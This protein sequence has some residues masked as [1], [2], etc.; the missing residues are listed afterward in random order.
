MELPPMTKKKPEPAVERRLGIT[1]MNANTRRATDPGHEERPA[2]EVVEL[3]P[4]GPAR[5]T[6][7]LRAL[8]GMPKPDATAEPDPEVGDVWTFGQ[9]CM[10]NPAGTPAV[11]YERYTIARRPGWSFVFVNGAYDG[12]SPDDMAVFG[13]HFVGHAEYL[14]NYR[15]TNVTVLAR[16]WGRGVF[17][18]AFNMAPRIAQNAVITD[19]TP[20][21]ATETPPKAVEGYTGPLRRKSDRGLPRLPE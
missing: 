8:M 17:G 15:F 9:R 16:D 21:V 3:V 5:P 14:A 7:Y 10:G 1:P 4:T 18:Q 11:C 13:G 20:G 12:F 19:D 6:D 2:G